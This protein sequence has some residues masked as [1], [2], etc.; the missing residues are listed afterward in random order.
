MAVKIWIEYTDKKEL[1]LCIECA[2]S[3]FLMEDD[4][5]EHVCCSVD[6]QENS[7]GKCPQFKSLKTT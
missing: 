6:C 5:I 2:R 4:E 7:A 3:V 1:D